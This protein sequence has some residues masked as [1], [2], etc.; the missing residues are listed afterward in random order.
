M[1]NFYKLIVIITM[2]CILPKVYAISQFVI[3]NIRVNGLQ[4]IEVG[5]VFSYLPVKVG[6]TLDDNLADEIV[7]KLY[8]T[9]FFKDI[10]LEEQ[11]GTLIIDLQ[12]RPVISELTI[13]GDKAFDHDLLVKSLKDNGLT[14]GKI[15]DQSIIDQAVMSLKSEYY[16]RGLYSVVITPKVVALVRNRVTVNI[17]ID[18]GPPAKIVAIDFLGAKAFSSRQLEHQIFLTTGNLL[19]W[20]YKDNQ[21]SSDKLSGDLETIRNFYL[22]QGYINFKINSVQVQLSADKKSVYIS[23]NMVEGDQYTIKSVKLSGDVKNVPVGEL[24]ELLTI[25]SS[26]IVDQ[27]EI[28]KVSD[29]IKNKLGSYGYAFAAVNPVPEVDNEEKNVAYTFFIDTG[30]KIYVRKIN[31][32]GNDIT[33]DMVIRRELR[34]NENAL[35][36]SDQIQRSKDRLN[37]LGYFKSTDVSTTPV[38]GSNDEVDMNVKVEENN[39]GSIN[40]G[41]GYAQGQGVLLNGSVSQTNLFGSGKSASINAATSLLNQSLG[42]SFTDPYALPNGTSLGYDVYDNGYSPNKSNISPYSTQTLGG[43]I[44]TGVPVSEFDKINFSLGFENNNIS[45]Y[46]NNVPLRFI[47]FINTYGNSVNA[48]P[49]SVAWV[50]NTTDSTLWPTTGALFNEIADASLPSVGAQYYRLTSQNT[51]FFPLSTNFTWK[52]NAQLGFINPYGGSNAV[53]FYQ[54]FY[55][56]GINSVRGYYIGSM[57]PKDTDGSSLGGTR[58]IIFSNELMFP[59]PGLKETKTVR[60]SMFFDT[61]ALWGGNSFDLTPQQSFRASYGVGLNW[62]SPLGPIKLSYALPLFNQQTDQL[63]AFQFMLGSSF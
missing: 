2:F 31:V 53:P 21:Y 5:T 26:S 18:E 61:G 40:M 48:V 42:V 7:K 63:E 23:V 28:N 12:E 49:A 15:F 10:R 33:R 25:K 62:I 41:V 50:R 1:K 56:G 54:S 43:R 22:N 45:T 32:T 44:R 51:W 20:W 16:N 57:G 34:Q 47:Q 58:S 46:G 36:N 8:T 24:R 35:Y 37:L 59:L 19:S 9:G 6:D 38:P 30:K 3:N 4:R 27:G 55:M 60:L 11:G 17:S 29:N 13:T 52:T 39:T 14:A